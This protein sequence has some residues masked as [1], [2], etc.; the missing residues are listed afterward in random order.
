METVHNPCTHVTPSTQRSSHCVHTE[1]VNIG[2]LQ[3]K[4]V[5]MTI[6]WI[7]EQ[8]R[9][10]LAKERKSDRAPDGFDE[11]FTQACAAQKYPERRRLLLKTSFRS[12]FIL[13]GLGSPEVWD[14]VARLENAHVVALAS[15][16]ADEPADAS[17]DESLRHI[18]TNRGQVNKNR[19]RMC[20]SLAT[21]MG[22]S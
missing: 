13:D 22:T 11:S 10:F 8:A 12:W 1:M 16:L 6:E 15:R 19:L 2:R 3:S 5:T 18:L 14:A 21:P 20:S 9:P 7:V 4:S 17:L